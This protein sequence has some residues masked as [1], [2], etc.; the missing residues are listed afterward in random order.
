NCFDSYFSHNC[1]GLSD[2]MFC[3]N[4]KNKR[5]AVGNAALEPAKYK[6]VRSALLEQ[7]VTEIEDKKGLELD[8]FNIGCYKKN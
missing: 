7:I 2:A 1:E 8:I 5:H 6:A 4:T 3:F